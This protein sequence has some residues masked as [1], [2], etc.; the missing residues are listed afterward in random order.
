MDKAVMKNRRS[1]IVLKGCILD[2][3]IITLFLLCV[4][5]SLECSDKLYVYMCDG[6]IFLNNIIHDKNGSECI[7]MCSYLSNKLQDS[8]FCNLHN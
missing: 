1:V 3:S 4:L 8:K 7:L 6:I 5:I 2:K